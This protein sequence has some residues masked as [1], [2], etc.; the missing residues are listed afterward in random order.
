MQPDQPKQAP[1]QIGVSVQYIKDF[2]F[3][4]PNVPQIFAP[5]Q[6][7]P[8]IDMGV[9]VH[10]RPLAD[11][12]YEVLLMLKME[13]R[14][15][16]KAAFI[17]ELAYGGVFT[18]PAMPEDQLKLVLLIECPRILF[19]FARSVMANAV[20]DGGFPQILINPIDFAAL[21]QANKD[22][23]GTLTTAGAA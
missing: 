16:G 20:R 7:P 13:V 19:P 3:E 15:D 11:K 5:T 17:A 22:S 2:S 21:Y 12:T 23:L 14:F 9:N 10:T 6:N 8:D 1:I 18:L 4:C